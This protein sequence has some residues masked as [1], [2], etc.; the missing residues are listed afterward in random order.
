MVSALF[1]TLISCL[2][3]GI[4]IVISIGVS[5]CVALLFTDIPFAIVAKSI[6]TATDI[7]PLQAVPLF[8]LAGAIMEVA[9]V[10]EQIVQVIERLVGWMRGG[11]AMAV[12]IASMF[13]GAMSGSGPATAAAIGFI[14]IPALASRGYDKAYSA[15]LTSSAG[16]LGILIPPSNP[17]IVYGVVAQASIIGL[18]VAGII[19]GIMVTSTMIAISYAICFKRNYGRS[20]IKFSLKE[21]LPILWRSKWSLLAPIII[22]GGIYGGAFTAVEASV[23]AVNYALFLG[24][25]VTKKLSISD[26]FECFNKTTIIAGSMII[27]VGISTSFGEL[28]TLY[29]VPQMIAEFLISISSNVNVIFLLVILFLI[30]LGTFMDTMA[31]IIILTPMLLPV[32]VQL[33]IHP[34]HFGI[35]FVVTNEIAFLTPPVGA[36]LFVMAGITKIPIE[37]IAKEEIVFI[38][39]LLIAVIILAWFPEISLY[40]PKKLGYVY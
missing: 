39:G 31:T 5:T 34:I 17:M 37:K 6:Y 3:L 13:F 36:N 7:F 10:S 18:F 22:L 24:I 28:L 38:I 2:L 26:I 21:F 12:V 14:M 20:T 30:I 29:Q 35:V 23:V 4:P 19:P 11:L 8:I 9:G 27:L 33:G 25:F 1:L 16:T 40:L 15:A 32:M